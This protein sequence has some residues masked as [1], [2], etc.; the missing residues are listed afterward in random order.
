[1]L[2][3][4]RV[5]AIEIVMVLH[6]VVSQI[7]DGRQ[8]IVDKPG[9]ELVDLVHEC[10]HASDRHRKCVGISGHAL[11]RVALSRLNRLETPLQMLHSHGLLEVNL[12]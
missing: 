1:M 4:K 6:T 12:R 11:H 10:I 8:D 3:R 9:T 2:L 5:C 7:M